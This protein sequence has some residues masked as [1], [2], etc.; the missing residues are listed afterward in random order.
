MEKLR[1]SEQA[2]KKLKEKVFNG[3][4][5]PNDDDA[6]FESASMMPLAVLT[7]IKY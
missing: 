2:K 6:R 4:F 1:A 7:M 3:I 5:L